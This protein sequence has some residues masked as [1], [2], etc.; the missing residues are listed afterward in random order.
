LADFGWRIFF[1]P[2]DSSTNR[3]RY[4]DRFLKTELLPDFVRAGDPL[5]PKITW[6]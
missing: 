5:L 1:L 4:R 6:N 3:I 2:S